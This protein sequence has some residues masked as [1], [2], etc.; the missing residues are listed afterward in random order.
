MIPSKSPLLPSTSGCSLSAYFAACSGC[1]S[2]RH[3]SALRKRTR[4]L[5]PGIVTGL[6]A[7]LSSRAASWDA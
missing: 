4:L 2:A 3:S 1:L 5:K 6:T 7:L